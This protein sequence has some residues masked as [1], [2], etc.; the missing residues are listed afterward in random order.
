MEEFYEYRMAGRRRAVWLCA[1]LIV[2][3]IGIAN[4][5]DP[6]QIIWVIYA[7]SASMIAW[8]VISTPIAGIRLDHE[9]LT[10]AAFRSP[11]EVRLSEIDHVRPTH[12]TEESDIVLVYR[13]GREEVVSS[14][15]LP[16]F[17][18][19][20]ELMIARGIPVKDPV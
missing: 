16:S 10:L 19:F 5:Y 3:M 17:A 6:P 14:G 12:W 9:T 2:F 15:D 20:E 18:E 1:I 4:Q 13:D 8:M 7:V 11:R